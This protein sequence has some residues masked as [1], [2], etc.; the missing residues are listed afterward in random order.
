MLPVRTSLLLSPFQ[1]SLFSIFQS[2]ILDSRVC[3]SRFSFLFFY[4]KSLLSKSILFVSLCYFQSL[5]PRFVSILQS[6]LLSIFQACILASQ[7]YL[8]QSLVYFTSLY[9]CFTSLFQSSILSIIQSHILASRVYF[10][11]IGL[12]RTQIGRQRQSQIF[13]IRKLP[14]V[15]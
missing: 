13:P 6:S 7:V 15:E 8:V 14:L 9:T 10:S 3:F 2:Y 4:P 12:N 1:Q 11:R 5:H